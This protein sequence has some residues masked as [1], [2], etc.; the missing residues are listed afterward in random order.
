MFKFWK[1]GH[2]RRKLGNSRPARAIAARLLSLFSCAFP[3]PEQKKKPCLR[4][5]FLLRVAS[6][7]PRLDLTL[8]DVASV[9][10]ALLR[11]RLCIVFPAYELTLTPNGGELKI[12]NMT[13]FCRNRK[14]N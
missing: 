8:Y 6:L 10:R 1:E 3:G 7:D 9:V 14:S 4:L 11:P 13:L 5:F 12:N 2:A